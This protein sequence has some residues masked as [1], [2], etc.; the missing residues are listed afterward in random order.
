MG[1]R[2]YFPPTLYT[3]SP[4]VK[5]EMKKTRKRTEMELNWA[6]RH[7]LCQI[8]K[9]KGPNYRLK[10]TLP[11]NEKHEKSRSNIVAIILLHTYIV[12]LNSHS[13]QFSCHILTKRIIIAKSIPKMLCQV[14]A[15]KNFMKTKRISVTG[16]MKK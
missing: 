2:P 10:I 7:L 9:I 15:P 3:E 12:Q 5:V 14:L 16:Y 1:F 6:W 4:A 11:C 8:S 13:Q